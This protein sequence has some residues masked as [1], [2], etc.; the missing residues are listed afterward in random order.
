VELAARTEGQE[1]LISVRD[2]GIGIAPEALPRV[3]DMF[4]QPGL[5]R[6]RGAGIG[7]SLARSLAGLHGG[8]IEVKSDGPGRGS[9]FIVRLPVVTARPAEARPAEATLVNARLTSRRVLVVDD[10]RDSADS[11]AEL[12]ALLGHEVATAYDGEEALACI[13]RAAPEVV[14]LDIGMPKLDGYAACRRIR[15]DHRDVF[16][17]AVT[18]WG[19]D[20]DVR[21]AREAGFD[22]HLVKPVD[23]AALTDL[24]G[25]LRRER[26]GTA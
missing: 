8:S 11:L 24:L 6:A 20:A 25:G 17:V 5:E 19:Q 12:L 15:S 23:L 10:V 7:L 1:V 3:F 14:L 13:A 22:A 16:L 21:H 9:E 4:S 18:G 2:D 26:T